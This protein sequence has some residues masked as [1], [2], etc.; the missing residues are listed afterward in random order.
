MPIEEAMQ[1]PKLFVWDVDGTLYR[2]APL[3]AAILREFTRRYWKRPLEG[4]VQARILAAH[5]RALEHLRTGD[6]GSFSAAAHFDLTCQFSGRR[7]HQVR[8]CL[9]EWFEEVPLTILPHCARPGLTG[10]LKALL[11]RRVPLAVFSDYEP[12]RKIAALGLSGYFALM[13]SASDSGIRTLKPNP[14][15]L[16]AVLSRMGVDPS[17]AVY[18]GDRP[19]LDALAARRAGMRAVIFGKHNLQRADWREVIHVHQ[20]QQLVYA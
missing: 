17:E 5:R 18:I 13:C 15:G 2:Q 7:S 14:R 4:L 11:L 19:E 8:D 9:A 20:L 12:R 3:R 6:P 16:Q 1:Q 10:L